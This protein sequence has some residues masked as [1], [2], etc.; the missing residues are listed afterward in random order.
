MEERGIRIFAPDEEEPTKDSEVFFN[1]EMRRNRD[2]SEI[3]LSVFAGESDI[4][5]LRAVDALAGTGIRGMR[6]AGHADRVFLNDTNPSAVENIERALDE[7]GIDAE[8]SNKDA[9]VLLSE[10]RNYF[11][12]ID[13]DPFGPFTSFLDSAARATNHNGFAGFT[14]TDNAVAAGSYVKT[15]RRRYGVEPMDESF[16]HEVGLRIYIGEVFRNYAR[17]DKCFDPKISFHHRHYSRVM[18]R[19]TESKR[20]T[21]RSLDSMGYLSFCPDCRWRGFERREEC[22]VC[23]SGTRI[24][25][26]LWTGKF[27]DRRFTEKM[28][29]EFPGDWESKEFLETVHGESEILTPFYDMHELASSL[30]VQVPPRDDVLE[31]IEERGYPVSETH[32]SPT[33]FRTDAPVEDVRQIIEDLSP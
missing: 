30:K 24:A 11:H 5:E 32:F 4:D 29:E 19:V 12:F 28:L 26:P 14:A 21:N 27:V 18:G 8:V 31:A 6:Y 20:R 10:H 25:G 33:G 9:N 23:G 22:P 16:M 15:C 13:I 2:L 3:A 17:F 7:N 1:E